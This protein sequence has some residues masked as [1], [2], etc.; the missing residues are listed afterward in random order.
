MNYYHEFL[1]KMM[2]NTLLLTELSFIFVFYPDK[3]GF[4][5]MLLFFGI[6]GLNRMIM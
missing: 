6:I 2:K 3:I 4:G 5:R 1:F